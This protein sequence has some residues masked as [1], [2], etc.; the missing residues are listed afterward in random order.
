MPTILS[1]GGF[2][3]LVLLPPREHGPA[4][5]HVIKDEGVAVI[6]L[7]YRGRHQCLTKVKDMRTPDVVK[8]FRLVEQHTTQ[9]IEA[10]RRYHGEA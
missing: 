7:S 1:I 10:W 2:R 9:L 3:I 6:E 4:H 5:V 8:A